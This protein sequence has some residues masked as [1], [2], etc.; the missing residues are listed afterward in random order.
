[1]DI[2]W[3]ECVCVEFCDQGSDPCSQSGRMHVHETEAPCPV[4]PGALV[5]G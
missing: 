2:S 1:M 3:T 4:H 5:V